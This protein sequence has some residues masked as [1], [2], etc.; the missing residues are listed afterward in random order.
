MKKLINFTLR[1]VYFHSLETG[2]HMKSTLYLY[3]KSPTKSICNNS[4]ITNKDT[5]ESILNKLIEAV[6][7]K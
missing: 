3:W 5:L 7:K 2:E 6:T 1:G 4:F